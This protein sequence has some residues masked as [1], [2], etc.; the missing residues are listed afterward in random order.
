MLT[1]GAAKAQQSKSTKSKNLP[2]PEHQ[3]RTKIV[4]LETTNEESD[5][6]LENELD[7]ENALNELAGEQDSSTD[8]DEVCVP[9]LQQL[10][11]GWP[12]WRF[13]IRLWHRLCTHPPCCPPKAHESRKKA[14]QKG[15]KS[16]HCETLLDTRN[17][18]LGTHPS[19]L[20]W[21]ANAFLLFAIRDYNSTTPV[22]ESKDREI[23]T[24]WM[25]RICVQGCSGNCSRDDGWVF[26]SSSSD[27][28]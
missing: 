4:Q 6:D 13:R 3:K 23:K 11:P 8:D 20:L 25:G 12:D 9:F 22:S 26:N 2:D 24:F 17:N 19:W 10:I 28:V 16:S 21:T 5:P 14:S 15:G 18:L 7:E 1:K 27:G